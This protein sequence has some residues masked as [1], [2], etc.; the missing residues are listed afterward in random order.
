MYIIGLQ[1]EAGLVAVSLQAQKYNNKLIRKNSLLH[2]YNATIYLN[3]KN[4]FI[5]SKYRIAFCPYCVNKALMR[6]I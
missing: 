2:S 3:N 6:I 5:Y 4:C 1:I